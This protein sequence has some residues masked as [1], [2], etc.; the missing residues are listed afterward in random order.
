MSADL[1]WWIHHLMIRDGERTGTENP[2]PPHATERKEARKSVSLHF[3]F[4]TLPSIIQRLSAPFITGPPTSRILFHKFLMF[5]IFSSVFR[6]MWW[7]T[8]LQSSYNSLRFASRQQ[9]R[10][11]NILFRKIRR[12]EFI[13]FAQKRHLQVFLSSLAAELNYRLQGAVH[14]SVSGYYGIRPRVAQLAKCL[15]NNLMWQ[16]CLASQGK[17]ESV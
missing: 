11:E 12:R 13:F 3:S 8:N 4:F 1:A 2:S 15:A 10:L 5:L 9:E 7:V 14:I 16:C 17:T 6:E